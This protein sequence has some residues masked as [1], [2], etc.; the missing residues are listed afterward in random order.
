MA[1]I[2]AAVE[3]TV[4]PLRILVTST[5]A[6]RLLI[7]HILTIPIFPNRISISS[8][9]RFSQNMSFEKLLALI[10]NEATVLEGIQTHQTMT[11]DPFAALLGNI[12]AFGQY[13]ITKMNKDTLVMTI[14]CT[15]EAFFLKLSG[16]VDLYLRSPNVATTYG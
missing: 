6:L 7:T 15:S 11:F 10:A 5:T 1:S 16:V 2:S 8:L 12:L 3:L 4:R 13:N 9:A 14:C